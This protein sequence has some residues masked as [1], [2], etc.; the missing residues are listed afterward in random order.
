MSFDNLGMAEAE[1]GATLSFTSALTNISADPNHAGGSVLTGGVYNVIDQFTDGG[2]P[3]AA[4]TIAISG[5]GANKITTLDATVDLAGLPSQ[6]TSN[7]VSLV[8]SLL[9]VGDGGDLN[10][11]YGYNSGYSQNFADPNAVTIDD[12]GQVSVTGA[13]FSTAGL[14]IASGGYLLASGD[15]SGAY[16]IYASIEGAIVNNGLIVADGVEAAGTQPTT[17]LGGPI[18]GTG[19]IDLDQDAL[20]EFG[21]GV[22]SGQTIYFGN[23]QVLSSTQVVGEQVAGEETIRIDTTSVD[24]DGSGP[25]DFAATIADFTVGDAID[26]SNFDDMTDYSFNGATLTVYFESDQTATLNFSDLADETSFHFSSDGDGGTLITPGASA[27]LA[28][29]TGVSATDGVT[30]DAAVTGTGDAGATLVFTE[31]GDTLGTTVVEDNGLWSFTPTGLE[32]GVQTIDGERG[33][34]QLLRRGCIGHFR[35][36][37]ATAERHGLA[38]PIRPDQSNYGRDLRRGHGR[39]CRRQRHRFG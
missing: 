23:D 18:S 36:R 14:T 3:G 4:S 32:D 34:R 10:L 39:G 17:Y 27:E 13:D 22:G 37:H 9:E 15:F 28:D 35:A 20:A 31:N 30:N 19:S 6:L 1:N 38:N 12:G 16:T 5:N 33:K 24:P 29:D 2:G 25:N 11:Y 8:N 21:G 26:L 7:G